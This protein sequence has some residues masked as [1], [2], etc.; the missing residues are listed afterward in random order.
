MPFRS[1]PSPFVSGFKIVGK[2]GERKGGG[3]SPGKIFNLEGQKRYF[4]ASR[5]Q[6]SHFFRGGGM[7]WT[8]LRICVHVGT[9]LPLDVNLSRWVAHAQVGQIF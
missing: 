6:K 5:A 4:P 8:Q 2:S 7:M 9:C 1:V 3:G